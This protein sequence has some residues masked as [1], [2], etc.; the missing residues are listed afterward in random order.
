LKV[1]KGFQA[2][3]CMS[4]RRV[5]PSTPT[6]LLVEDEVLTRLLMTDV[7]REEGYT[8]I[9]VA[10]GDEGRAF[11]LSGEPVDL[12][13]TDVDMPGDTDGIALTALA[14]EMAPA[15]PVVVVSS[16]LPSAAAC[17]ADEFIP[18]PYLPATFLEVVFNL[19]GPAH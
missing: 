16:R 17:N 8:V 18:K 11:L 13:V 9:E 6:I 5:M 4:G 3:H 2:D 19:I 12:V 14:K 15:R 10:C 7:L 1:P